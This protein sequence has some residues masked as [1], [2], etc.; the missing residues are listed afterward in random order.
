M[1]RRKNTRT[2]KK[3]YTPR[4]NLQI[5]RKT[6]YH[7]QTYQYSEAN[8]RWT[9]K[10][11]HPELSSSNIIPQDRK[12][13]IQNHWNNNRSFEKTQ[14]LF[15][16]DKRKHNGREFRARKNLYYG[17]YSLKLS[18]SWFCVIC[19]NM[20]Y[21]EEHLM[22]SSR[23]IESKVLRMAFSKI[24]KFVWNKEFL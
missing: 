19:I 11:Q 16:K 12:I 20:D 14:R 3:Y 5:Q 18:N 9:W 1:D 13:N 4:I 22:V 23:E 8:L 24:I 6:N 15:F 21:V 10:Q 2:S 17:K 7:I